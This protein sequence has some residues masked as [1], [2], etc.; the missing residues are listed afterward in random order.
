MTPWTPDA[1]HEY[2]EVWMVGPDESVAVTPPHVAGQPRPGADALLTHQVAGQR[3]IVPSRVRAYERAFRRGMAPTTWDA[4]AIT[5]DGLTANAIHRLLAIVGSRAT[6]KLLVLLNVSEEAIDLG[7]QGQ[8]RN[9]RQT[10]RRHGY[11]YPGTTAPAAT[12]MHR[13]LHGRGPGD[14]SGAVT[15]DDVSLVLAD[16]PKL[17][18]FGNLGRQVADKGALHSP[19]L[20]TMMAYLI[21]QIDPAGGRRH[22]QRPRPGA[23]PA[24]VAGDRGRRSPRHQGGGGRNR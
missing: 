6:V 23:P 2:A 7:D 15:W 22:Q 5:R 16:H 19:G 24:Q 11:E 12:M 3:N 1:G 10:L 21:C 9:I 8:T 13:W 4:L 18:A 14:R 20:G 17:D